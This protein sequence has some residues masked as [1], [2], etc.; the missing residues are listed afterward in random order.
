MNPDWQ[1][2]NYM[3]EVVI[4]KKIFLC[5][6]HFEAQRRLVNT[7]AGAKYHEE[8]HCP[9]CKAGNPVKEPTLME[10]ARQHGLQPAGINNSNIVKSKE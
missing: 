1:H 7:M 5:Q 10:L 8:P 4:H 9:E 2:R 6:K 3:P